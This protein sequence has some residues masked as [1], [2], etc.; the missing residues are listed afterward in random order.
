MKTKSVPVA[1]LLA[2]VLGC[3]QEAP[4]PAASSPPPAAPVPADSVPAPASPGA[5]PQSS[6]GDA[7]F[8]LAPGSFRLCDARNGA[9]ASTAR[10]DAT[11]KDIGE[12]SIY[13][14]DAKGERKLWLD[15]GASGESTTGEWVFPDTMFQLVDRASGKPIAELTVGATPCG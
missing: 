15:G 7:V 12:V 6:I 10:W 8:S 3:S 2:C 1:L 14:I 13:V 11:A 5:L 9:I 4:G